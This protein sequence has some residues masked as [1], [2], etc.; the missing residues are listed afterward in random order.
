MNSDK[1]LFID[2]E[3]GGLDPSKYSLL[4]I[5]FVVWQDFKILGAK[6]IF[7]NDGVL[8][9]TPE[10]LEI[11]GI[12]LKEHITKSI[13]PQLA[14]KEMSEFLNLHFLAEEKITL[15]GH[16]I[17]FDINF[18]KHLLSQNNYLFHVRFTH[19]NID[20]ATIL[21][22]LY[23][24]N[25]IKQKALSSDEAFSLFG[26]NIEGRHTALGD[27]VATAKLFS[28]LVRLISKNVKIK[29]STTLPR[30]FD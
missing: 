18:F 3:T 1:I 22:F 6:E 24:G 14:I 4:S 28:I 21:Y 25:K 13:S 2:T 16:N 20:T 10:A 19:R 17:N 8:E 9:A 7:I 30:L 27:A 15:A 29:G 11:N 26:I 12:D 5:A 23:L